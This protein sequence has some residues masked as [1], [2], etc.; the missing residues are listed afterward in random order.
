MTA[1]KKSELQKALLAQAELKVQ[2][3]R[4]RKAAEEEEKRA[5]KALYTDEEG[6]LVDRWAKVLI[7]AREMTRTQGQNSYIEWGTAITDILAACEEFSLA[8]RASG[9]SFLWTNTV[10]STKIGQ[11]I[12][13]LVGGL[14]TAAKYKVGETFGFIDKAKIPPIQYKVDVSN[15]G[16]IDT[17]LLID[18]KK[19]DPKEVLSDGKTA[20]EHFDVL[21]LLWA[22]DNG[23]TNFDPATRKLTKADGKPMTPEIFKA[24]NS[25]PSTRLDKRLTDAGLKIEP[26]LSPGLSC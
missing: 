19:P 25:D 7:R 18:G 9:I 20:Q 3:E 24:L 1:P 26:P 17:M 15:E 22:E 12:S 13:G 6:K 23:Y 21:L 11:Q 8:L 2:H 16:V 5:R 4:A 10:G 14:A